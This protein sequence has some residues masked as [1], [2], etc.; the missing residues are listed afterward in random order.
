MLSFNRLFERYYIADKIYIP[1]YHA[2]SLQNIDEIK[3][4]TEIENYPKELYYD[5]PVLCV[6]GT[7]V[8]PNEKKAFAINLESEDFDDFDAFSFG[9][10]GITNCGFLQVDLVSS[11]GSVFSSTVSILAERWSYILL[12]ISN[13]EF[14]KNIKEIKFYSYGE[15]SKFISVSIIQLSDLCFGKICDFNFKKGNIEKLF[16]PHD[17]IEKLPNSLRFSFFN[18]ESL[19]FPKLYKPRYSQLNCCFVNKDCIALSV[20]NVGTCEKFKIY[21]ASDKQKDFA[22]DRSISIFIPVK[23]Y[24]QTVLVSLDCLPFSESER[25]YQLKLEPQQNEGVLEILRINFE[26]EKDFFEG[27]Y[28]AH[29]SKY[30][31]RPKNP[32]AFDC[33]PKIF[34]VKDY[35]AKGDG[36]T[37]DTKAIQSAIDFAFISGGGKVLLSAGRFIATHIILKSNIEFS[38]DKSSI[39]LQSS[40]KE[41]YDYDV[42]YEHDNIHYRSP[43]PH[44]FLVHNKPLIYSVNSKNIKLTG[45]GKIRMMDSGSEKNKVGFPYWPIS[46]GGIIHIAPIGFSH[47]INLEISDIQINRA[48]TYHCFLVHCNNVFIHNI[49]LFDVRCLSADGIGLCGCKNVIISSSFIQTNDDGITLFS[50]YADPRACGWWEIPIGQ[51]NSVRNVEILGCYVD[52]AYGGGGKAISF[53]PWGTGAPDLTKQ[54]ISEIH[55][56]NCVLKGGHSIG[57]WAD[58]PYHGKQPFDNSEINDYSPVKN[59]KIHNNTYLDKVSLE[60][61]KA[62]CVES[63]CGL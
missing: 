23:K 59:L 22:E 43:W 28:L 13:C 63:D 35:G 32:Y 12:D 62:T 37:N 16:F 38:I 8:S 14:R 2:Q 55:I 19:L 60:Y 40:Q 39:L 29:I 61:I 15:S 48:S 57:A 56:H 49:K 25:L 24:V 4:V 51:D 34:N 17:C 30:K 53:I 58:N 11:K 18:G 1:Y 36:Y 54:E 33:C 52:S 10:N 3:I 21:I 42:Q 31:V 44:N 9:V 26:Q 7:N 6:K 46:C 5:Q 41:D 27:D 20:K 50:V 47:C 45:G